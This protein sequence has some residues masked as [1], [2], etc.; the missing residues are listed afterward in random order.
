MKPWQTIL[1]VLDAVCSGP[2]ASS[3]LTRRSVAESVSIRNLVSERESQIANRFMSAWNER[4]GAT[5]LNVGRTILHFPS[6]L[7]GHRGAIGNPLQLSLMQRVRHKSP[8]FGILLLRLC[9]AMYPGTHMMCTEAAL[10]LD[11]DIAFFITSIVGFVIADL[12]HSL[13][14][15]WNSCVFDQR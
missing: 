6:E 4:F 10:H 5:T 14:L 11:S 13:T 2:P 8:T 1:L 15:H 12:Q 9:W 7:R 3:N